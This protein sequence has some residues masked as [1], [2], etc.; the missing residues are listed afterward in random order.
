MSFCEVNRLFGAIKTQYEFD[1]TI[2]RH[3]KAL[4]LEEMKKFSDGENFVK[5]M[6]EAFQEIES[7]SDDVTGLYNEHPCDF[8]VRSAKRSSVKAKIFRLFRSR[9]HVTTQSVP[10][11]ESMGSSRISADAM[12]TLTYC[13][14]KLK[15]NVA[16][17]VFHL[18]QFSCHGETYTVEHQEFLPSISANDSKTTDSTTTDSTTTDSTTTDSA[19]IDSVSTDLAA[20]LSTASASTRSTKT[21]DV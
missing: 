19:S 16:L 11:D 5:K 14:Y 9:S 7:S 3:Q 21:K 20:T 18:F 2:D 1:G 8:H 6:S 13:R 17:K 4:L 10:N 12:G 15:F